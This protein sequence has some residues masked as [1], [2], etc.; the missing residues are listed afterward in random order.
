MSEIGNLAFL[1]QRTTGVLFTNEHHIMTLLCESSV[2]RKGQPVVGDLSHPLCGEYELLA[3]VQRYGTIIV[4][5]L[6][7]EIF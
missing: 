4:D 6:C 7:A 5:F 3:S 1:Y 2:V